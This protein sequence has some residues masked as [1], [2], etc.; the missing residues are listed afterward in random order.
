MPPAGDRIELDRTL[1]LLDVT[2]AAVDR[3]SVA[4]PVKDDGRIRCA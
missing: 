3:G 4:V 2:T 1:D